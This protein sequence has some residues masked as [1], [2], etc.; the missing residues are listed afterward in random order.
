MTKKKKKG[1]KALNY[2][3]CWISESV[4]GD[5]VFVQMPMPPGLDEAGLRNRDAIRRASRKAV[6]DLGLEEYGNKEFIVIAYGDQF[7]IPYERTT[8][9]RLLPPDKA[10]KVKAENG[11]GAGILDEDED[12]GRPDDVGDEIASEAAA[13]EAGEA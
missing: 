5:K 13:E 2:A 4:D 1:R 6:Y 11:N 12:D 7:S 8:V 9:T 10:A 3:L